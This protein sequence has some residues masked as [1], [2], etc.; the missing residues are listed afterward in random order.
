MVKYYLNAV[1]FQIFV[2]NETFRLDLNATHV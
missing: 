1:D 2:H